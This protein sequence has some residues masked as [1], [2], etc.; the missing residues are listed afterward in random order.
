M[1]GE[2]STTEIEFSWRP[3]TL[4]GK[5]LSF[6]EHVTAR[7]EER[8]CNC[9]GPAV[10]KWQGLLK[11]GPHSG[12]VGLL[13]G[14]TGDLRQR[15]KQYVAGTQD[16]GNKLWRETFLSIGDARLYTLD[17]HAFRVSGSRGTTSV[18]PAEA[19]ASNNMRLVLEQILVMQAVADA[20]GS[21]WVVNGRQ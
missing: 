4:D 15:I 9:W 6:A 10:Y 12:K 14:E 5:H 18:P 11:S 20:N 19:L 21:I 3:S 16:R 7:L 2:R 1:G 17:L 8:R 13:I